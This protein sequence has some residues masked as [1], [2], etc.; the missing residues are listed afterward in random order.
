MTAIPLQKQAWRSPGA[1]VLALTHSLGEDAPRQE[2]VPLFPLAHQPCTALQKTLLESS[3][4]NVLP[5]PFSAG[6]LEAQNLRSKLFSTLVL[7][8]LETYN[9]Q[10]TTRSF[11]NTLNR[12]KSCDSVNFETEW[13]SSLQPH[14]ECQRPGSIFPSFSEVQN[15]FS[16]HW[17]AKNTW[18][19]NP[20]F[21]TNQTQRQQTRVSK[22][23]NLS[24]ER[25]Q[26]CLPPIPR[27]TPHP[28]PLSCTELQKSYK[29]KSLY[30][31]Q[32]HGD[33]QSCW[34]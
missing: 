14:T 5:S 18:G 26:H 10:S 25:P 30:W 6:E 19:G 15:S 7:S 24:F 33:S 34:M 29:N 22:S 17:G 1:I 27:S 3:F 31:S 8:Y 9:Q 21:A 11:S 23:P 16:S 4:R 2:A 12:V 20:T 28:A 32:N 13:I